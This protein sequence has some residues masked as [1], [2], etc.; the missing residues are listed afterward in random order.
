MSKT[1]LYV[2]V[3]T[4][5]QTSDHQLEQARKA[6]FQIDDVVSDHGTSGVTTKLADRDGGK[7]LFDML[8]EGDTLLVRW[9]DRLGRNYPDVTDTIR[10]FIREGV[11]IKTVINGMVFDGTTADPTQKAI[12]DALIGF[13]AAMAEAQVEANKEAQ[14]A[15]IEHHKATS[16]EKFKGRKPTFDRASFEGVQAM[17]NAGI[18]HSAI[19]KATGVNRNAVIRIAQDPTKAEAALVKWG[20]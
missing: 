17:L 3:S 9:V 4:T 12:R 8:R 6:G 18:G 14:R 7:R 5:E 2:R 20:M 15:G 19:A 10:E 13:M 11:T 16:P 1:I